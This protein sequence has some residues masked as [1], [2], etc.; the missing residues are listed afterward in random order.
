MSYNT[1][2]QN[3]NQE[4]QEILN[5]INELPDAS[6]GENGATFT[7]SVSADGVIS[8]TNDKGLDN[9]DPVNIKGK[10][11]DNYVITDADKQEIKDGIISSIIT[12]EAGQSESLVMSQKA[13]TD[14]VAE[15]I[16]TGGGGSTEYETVDSVAEMTNT[17]K[18]YVLKETGTI[19]TYGEVTVEKEPENVFVPANAT[20]NKRLGSSSESA[21]NG[22]YITEYL[23]YDASTASSSIR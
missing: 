18:Q 3:N 6:A 13:V 19:W 16:G 4:L 9:P 1:E 22:H 20:L 12:Q 8:W 11:G 5:T 10:K 21:Q 2:F 14:L 15:A 17:S 7:P 23:E